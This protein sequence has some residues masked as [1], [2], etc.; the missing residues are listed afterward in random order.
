MPFMG[1]SIAVRMSSAEEFE[2]PLRVGPRNC[3]EEEVDGDENSAPY[4]AMTELTQRGLAPKRNQCV[5]LRGFRVVERRIGPLK[6][7]AAARPNDLDMDRD[8]H[9]SPKVLS[10][11]SDS[12]F[13]D[14]FEL[15][16]KVRLA[17]VVDATPSEASFQWLERASNIIFNV[18]VCL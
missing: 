11:E 6:L 1:G 15:S 2:V 8:G 16:D 9:W 18:R 10:T 17:V 7:E 4:G 14:D 3:S 5:F 13:G 12:E